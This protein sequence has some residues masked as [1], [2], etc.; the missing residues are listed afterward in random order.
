[1]PQPG[2]S[3]NC[4]YVPAYINETA[5]EVLKT[6]GP[7]S[8]VGVVYTKQATPESI[9]SVLATSKKTIST[10]KCNGFR[11]TSRGATFVCYFAHT[12]NVG[13][14]AFE[15]Y[16]RENQAHEINASCAVWID[17][18]GFPV[19]I[20]SEANSGDGSSYTGSMSQTTICG[21]SQQMASR[22]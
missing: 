5:A 16:T 8:P 10:Y 17:P 11:Y 4:D 19:E 13:A 1:V 12:P 15:I 2:T 6:G 3:L 18:S 14:H 20:A 7:A 22:H 21:W 9:A